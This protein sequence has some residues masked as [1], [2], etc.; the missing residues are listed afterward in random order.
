MMG[1]VDAADGCVHGAGAC[2]DPAAVLDAYAIA[3]SPR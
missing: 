2:T 1:W 3:H